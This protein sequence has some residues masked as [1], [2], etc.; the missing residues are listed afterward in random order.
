MIENPANAMR[1]KSSASKR[2]TGTAAQTGRKR[3]ASQVISPVAQ[4]S[5]PASA[6]QLRNEINFDE[7]VRLNKERRYMAE[8]MSVAGQA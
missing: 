5:T 4:P 8:L 7:E 2:G 3:A 1:H 6:V